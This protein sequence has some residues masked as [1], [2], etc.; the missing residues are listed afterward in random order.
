[1]APKVSSLPSSFLTDA[2]L[3][4]ARWEQNSGPR[5]AVHWL[6]SWQRRRSVYA[7][8]WRFLRG[9]NNSMSQDIDLA[10]L[11]GA[12]LMRMRTFP[13]L[14]TKVHAPEYHMEQKTIALF[15]VYVPCTLRPL[16]SGPSWAKHVRKVYFSVNPLPKAR[17]V[18]AKQRSFWK[19]PHGRNFEEYR[20]GTT[21]WQHV[22]R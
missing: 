7:I 3:R 13:S 16:L 18:K 1:M 5:L 8:L 15:H 19:R 12:R 4:W 17:Y 21:L 20:Q 10:R 22:Q 14:D 6:K 2:S 11:F 9:Y